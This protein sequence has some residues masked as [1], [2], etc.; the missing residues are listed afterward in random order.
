MFNNKQAKN[1]TVVKKSSEN[2][3]SV[4]PQVLQPTFKTLDRAFK[5]MNTKGYA[6][7][8]KI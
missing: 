3:N 2:L 6:F 5:N 1:L 4:N 7:L 8:S